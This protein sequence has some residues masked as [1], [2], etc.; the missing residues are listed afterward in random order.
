MASLTVQVFDAHRRPLRDRMRVQVLAG[1]DVVAEVRDVPGTTAVRVP[2][3]NDHRSYAVR[4][5]PGRHRAIA[6]VLVTGS[7]AGTMHLFAPL[8]PKHAEP[9][10]PAFRELPS[11]LTEA[12]VTAASYGDLS[13]EKRAGLLNLFAKMTAEGVWSGVERIRLVHR[14]RI[15]ANVR[16]ELRERVATDARFRKVSGGMHVSPIAG[17][18]TRAG[19]WKTREPYGNLQLTFFRSVTGLVLVDA[20]VDDVAGFEH[21]FQVLG[22]WLTRGSTHPYD[23]H[24]LL[25]FAGVRPLYQI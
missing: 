18:E 20:D 1:Q 5:R 8:H 16:P 4:V 24:E 21:A 23:V 12:G 11:T 25:V 2:D 22:H 9:A 6:Q 19:S 3:L 14:D 15:F 7:G 10:L 13:D 17:Y